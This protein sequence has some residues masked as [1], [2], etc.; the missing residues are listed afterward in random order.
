MALENW[1]SSMFVS[2]DFHIVLENTVQ[3]QIFQTVIGIL[4]RKLLRIAGNCPASSKVFVRLI[5]HGGV[6]ADEFISDVTIQEAIDQS[7]K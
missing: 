3:F 6:S 7:G 4:Q 1:Q 2:F 5:N